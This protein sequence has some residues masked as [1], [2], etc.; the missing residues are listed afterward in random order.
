MLIIGNFLYRNYAKLF[1]IYN[2]L[3]QQTDIIVKIHV[4]HW[5]PLAQKGHFAALKKVKRFIDG[6]FY[7]LPGEVHD[8][9][10]VVAKKHK[11]QGMQLF[12]LNYDL[13]YCGTVKE[14]DFLYEVIFFSKDV[15]PFKSQESL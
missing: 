2:S 3:A 4:D 9:K 15:K 6:A 12:Y 13:T 14:F 5:Y 11:K 10:L 8:F 1:F 7:V